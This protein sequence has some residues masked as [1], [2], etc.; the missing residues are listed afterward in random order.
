[1]FCSVQLH[2]VYYTECQNAHSVEQ[3]D[4]ESREI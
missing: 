1:M 3:A 4:K 2:K